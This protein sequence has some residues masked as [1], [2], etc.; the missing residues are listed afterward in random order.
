MKNNNTTKSGV[1]GKI[2]V[3]KVVIFVL[4]AL[5]VTGL[6]FA[7]RAAYKYYQEANVLISHAE[8][9]KTEIKALANHVEKGN[10]EAANL[11]VQKIDTLSAEMR[12]IINEENWKLIQEKA[13]KYGDD[14][15]TATQFLDVIDEASNTIL[16]PGV[17]FLRE[18]GMPSKASF[19][20]IDSKLGQTLN[21]YSDLIDELSPAIEKVLND[22]NALP[23]F[24]MEKLESKVSK[25]RVLAKD[26]APEILTYLSFLKKTSDTLI[27]PAAKFLVD[28]GDSLKLD[29]DMDKVGPEMSAQ[30]LLFADAIDQF[31]PIVDKTIKEA[32]TLPAFKVEK[33]E[34]KLSKYRKLAKDNDADITALLKFAQ[35]LST[36][37][38]RPAAAVM[39][40]SPMSKLKTEEGDIDTKIIRDYL[41]LVER[42]KP[43][44]GRINEVIK[45]N[46]LLK[47]NAKLTA[48]I[49]PKLDKATEL[50]AQYDAYVPYI[51]VILG[52]G[53]DKTYMLIA[54]NSAEMRSSGGLPASIGIITIKDGILH[55]GQF[56]SFLSVLPFLNKGI[57]SFSKVERTI[58][59]ESWYT[60]KLTAAT[61][62]P[63]FPRAAE[64]L[65][66]GY[67]KQYKKNLDGIISMTPA[68]VGRLIAVTGP[69]TLS[70]KVKLDEKYAVKYLQRDVYFQYHTKKTITDE[71]LAS[72]ANKQENALFAEAAKKV[73][74]GVMSNLNLKSM[75]KLL[76]IVKKSSEDRVFCMWMADPK[77][78]EIVKNLGCSGSLNYDPKNPEL[79]VFFN[80]QAANKLGIYVN[81]KVTM[82]KKKVNKDGSV[83]YPVKVKIKNDIDSETL[84][85]GE[86]SSYLTSEFGGTMKAVVLFFAPSGGKITNMKSTYTT[87]KMGTATY[88]KLKLYYTKKRFDI[89]PKKTVTY[90]FNVT[91]APGV[92]VKPK[93]VT[94]PLLMEYRNAKAPK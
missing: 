5:V 24:Q 68:I 43:Y 21:E 36:G 92:D 61:V 55:I 62:N 74:S 52:D 30:L 75:I 93:V 91:T 86:K 27:R 44:I 63:H 8:G 76:D 66:K 38:I 32:N 40:R 10:Y 3:K 83:T 87:A 53:S 69:I 16:K 29:F 28:N 71:K 37:V 41:A 42:V 13:P 26:N 54:Q 19:S 2:T 46:K 31:C 45:S 65:A 33:V 14:L 17:K 77:D 85:K 39:E 94:T 4:I 58:L 79:G 11:S 89:L 15:K 20:K 51:N 90:T 88:K 67:K 73:I 7:G 34:A 57:N 82:G 80:V 23:T 22:F 49:T 18:K 25:Y 60:K 12:N 72:K 35:E 50:M 47:E 56:S 6:V 64:L 78:E 70:N 81:I 1:K 9:L 48:K 84:R 59:P